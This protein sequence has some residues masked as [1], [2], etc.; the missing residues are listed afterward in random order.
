VEGKYYTLGLYNE[1]YQ[2]R[3][4]SVDKKPNIDFKFVD[5]VTGSKINVN[6]INKNNYLLMSL[7]KKIDGN[8]I[9]VNSLNDEVL[10]LKNKSVD[11]NNKIIYG[12]LQK[13]WI[14]GVINFDL[15]QIEDEFKKAKD[16]INYEKY[17]M[18]LIDDGPVVDGAFKQCD[19]ISYIFQVNF[20]EK[21]DKIDLLKIFKLFELSDDVPFIKYKEP[22][23][24][25]PYYKIHKPIIDNV[26]VPRKV[27]RSWIINLTGDIASTDTI[28]KVNTKGINFKFLTHYDGSVPKFGTINL[29]KTGSMEVKLTYSQNYKGDFEKIKESID[30]V[31]LIINKI[32]KIDFSLDKLSKNK[33]KI[34]GP[35]FEITKDGD[36]IFG[37]NTETNFINTITNF[38]K[39]RK[40]D[41]NQ[42]SNLANSFTPYV[43]PV[44]S[45]KKKVVLN[46]LKLK[47]KRINNFKNL[48]E[49]FLAITRMKESQYGD[50]DIVHYIVKNYYKNMKEASEYLKEWN[51]KYGYEIDDEGKK[52]TES[53]I[54]IKIM[55]NNFHIEGV[56]SFRLLGNVYNFLTHFLSIYNDYDKYKKNPEFKKIIIDNDQKYI[57]DQEDEFVIEKEIGEDNGEEDEDFEIDLEDTVF[58]SEGDDF[59]S[60]YFDDEEE[61]VEEEGET[62]VEE[63]GKDSDGYPLSDNIGKGFYFECKM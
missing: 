37:K 33:N 31:N 26:S 38:S 45:D 27:V 57:E 61:G 53:G 1:G 10:F 42:L 44:S 63:G 4:P 8:E 30:K 24:I 47:Y 11:I 55:D 49:I 2:G 60:D 54:F 17:V 13:Y 56:K 43:I 25:V 32:N 7:V 16:Y 58:N 34:K 21:D 19:I 48:G 50:Y 51:K 23:W 9:F 39:I 15:L 18:N 22:D 3:E 41:F 46:T 52:L 59:I 5:K 20:G 35:E 12:Y 28:V 6:T 14:E 36:I 29:Y 62:K 40:I